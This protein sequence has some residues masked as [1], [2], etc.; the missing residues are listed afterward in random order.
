MGTLKKSNL[1]AAQV[2]RVSRRNL[3]ERAKRRCDWK[4]GACPRCQR[5]PCLRM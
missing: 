4:F 5:V 3:S 2:A 1:R